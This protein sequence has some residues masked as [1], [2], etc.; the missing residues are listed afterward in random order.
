MG[1]YGVFNSWYG[2]MVTMYTGPMVTRCICVLSQLPE[3]Q[4]SWGKKYKKKLSNLN[5]EHCEY[6][7]VI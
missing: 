7:L 1:R 3:V 6:Y 5:I 2:L 4:M